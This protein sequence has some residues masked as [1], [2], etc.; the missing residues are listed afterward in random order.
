M[1]GLGGGEG[2]GGGGLNAPHKV[3]FIVCFFFQ[4][5]MKKSVHNSPLGFV[6]IPLLNLHI[7]HC[8]QY[9]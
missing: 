6:V 8:M 1:T 5:S 2:G 9:T 7:F 4:P 3:I